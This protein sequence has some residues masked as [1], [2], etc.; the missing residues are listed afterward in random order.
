MHE[1][2]ST[3]DPPTAKQQLNLEQQQQQQQEAVAS[4]LRLGENAIV[5]SDCQIRGDVIIGSG[6]IIHPNCI[7]NAE[8][9]PIIIGSNNI[10]EERVQITN[11]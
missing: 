2:F 10:I 4:N 6:T 7:I 1:T 5:C 8:N 9:G 3:S 11:K